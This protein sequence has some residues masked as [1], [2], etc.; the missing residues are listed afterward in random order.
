MLLLIKNITIIEI[1]ALLQVSNNS[2]VRNL[3][4]RM[5]NLLI[6]KRKFEIL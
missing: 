1:L 4:F 5:L 3:L 2:S 6:T